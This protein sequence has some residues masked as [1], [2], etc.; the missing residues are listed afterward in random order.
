MQRSDDDLRLFQNTFAADNAPRSLDLLR[1]QYFEIPLQDLYV[2]FALADE[3]GSRLAA[4]HALAPVAMRIE[5]TRAVGAQSL[6]TLTDAAFR[7]RGLFVRMAA[8]AYERSARDG[9]RLVY[10]FPNL[11]SAH[12]LFQR[13]DWTPLDP[14]PMMGRPL[15]LA[16]VIHKASRGNVRLPQWLDL[17]I[18]RKRPRGRNEWELRRITEL[19]M[20]FDRLWERFAA[21]IPFAVER[22]SEYLR[23]RLRRPGADYETHGVF[24]GEQLLAYAIT[25][26]TPPQEHGR[27]GKIMELIHDLAEAEAATFLL[28]AAI[29]RFHNAGCGVVWAW[30]YGHSPNHRVFRQSGFFNVPERL[31]PARTR[32]GVRS[33]TTPPSAAAADT[34]KWYISM[35]DSDTD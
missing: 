14:L 12:G 15:R 24:R 26:I 33:L 8:A 19:T 3:S 6:D 18:P 4:I 31:I 1:W 7:G 32:V 34:T 30:N 29:E 28:R 5:G 23:W 11:N 2:D 35:L 25:S 13:L 17:A 10:G 27:S 21:A 9:V 22:D 20:D 16:Y